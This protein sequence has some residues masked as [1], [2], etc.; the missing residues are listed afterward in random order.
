MTDAWQEI[1]DYLAG[2]A[3]KLMSLVST[4]KDS[5]KHANLAP[6]T[7]QDNGPNDGL[8]DLLGRHPSDRPTPVGKESAAITDRAKGQELNK[9]TTTRAEGSKIAAPRTPKTPAPTAE[10]GETTSVAT[11]RPKPQ[12]PE[13]QGSQLDRQII[14][15]RE[16]PLLLGDFEVSQDSFLRDKPQ[17]DAAIIIL[18]PGTRIRVERRDGNYFRVRSLDDPKL[19]GYVHREDAFFEPIR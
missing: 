8:A 7:S 1:R 5:L 19:R 16:P 17:S 18:A 4:E 9:D 14:P 10:K 11:A 2:L 15:K 13:S 6:E 12:P 3:V